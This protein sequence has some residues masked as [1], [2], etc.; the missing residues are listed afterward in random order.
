MLLLSGS[1]SSIIIVLLSR[2]SSSHVRI[3]IS[4]RPLHAGRYATVTFPIEKNRLVLGI[5]FKNEQFM[6][7]NAIVIVMQIAGHYELSLFE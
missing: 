3:G 4:L 5:P 7:A 2:P 1:R 6:A